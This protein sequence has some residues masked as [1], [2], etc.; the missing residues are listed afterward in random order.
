MKR[1]I[2]IFSALGL[3]IVAAVALAPSAFAV[4]WQVQGSCVAPSGMSGIVSGVSTFS[5]SPTGGYDRAE[6]ADATN[7]TNSSIKLGLH[8]RAADNNPAYLV[9]S[10][11]TVG[12]GDYFIWNNTSPSV[13]Q[14][15][16]DEQPL[17]RYTFK[18]PSNPTKYTLLDTYS[19][20]QYYCWY[21][22]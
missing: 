15:S 18:N 13:T 8:W 22:G 3:A 9:L 14:I 19:G 6:Q 21:F 17:I 1:T 20:G 10:N 16:S 4:V 11:Y 7:G 5:L 12:Y 2:A